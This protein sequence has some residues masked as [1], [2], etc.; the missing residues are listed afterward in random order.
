M[1]EEEFYNNV[2]RMR[3]LQIKYFRTR[4]IIVL[5]KVKTFEKKV[6]DYIKENI[7]KK[8]I[9]EKQKEEINELFS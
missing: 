3:E 7:Y 6:D 1:K 4:N 2:K 5:Q 8:N 9:I